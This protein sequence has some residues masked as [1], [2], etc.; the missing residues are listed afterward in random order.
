MNPS[1]NDG[2]RLSHKIFVQ[3]DPE[4]KKIYETPSEM[5]PIERLSLLNVIE[6]VKQGYSLMIS[7]RRAS[8]LSTR[9]YSKG[10]CGIVVDGMVGIFF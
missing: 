8:E 2:T 9:K 6:N 4:V 10:N 7:I 3:P 5:N 1:V